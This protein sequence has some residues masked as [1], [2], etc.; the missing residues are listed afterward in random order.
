[1][2]ILVGIVGERQEHVDAANIASLPMRYGVGWVLR[3][4]TRMAPAAYWASWADALQMVDQRLPEMANRVL[5]RLE[6]DN[7]PAGCLGVQT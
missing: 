6:G 2:R 1:M 4:A 5:D 7:E 3:R